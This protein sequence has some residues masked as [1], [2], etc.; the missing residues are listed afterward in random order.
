MFEYYTTKAW[1]FSNLLGAE[2]REDLNE[3]ERQTYKVD[4]EDLDLRDYL[5]NCLLCIRRNILKETD[6]MIP[7]AKRNMK[8]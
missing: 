6:D 7:A 3:R 8:M 1:N 2:I 5:R 4:G